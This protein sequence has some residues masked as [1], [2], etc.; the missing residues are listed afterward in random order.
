MEEPLDEWND[1]L[2]EHALK[3]GDDLGFTKYFWKECDQRPADLA[4]FQ[5]F[6][7]S[8]QKAYEG[9]SSE[10]I[11]EHTGV[12]T[13]TV[14]SWILL[15]KMPKLAHYLK[16]YLLL[17]EPGGGLVWLSVDIGTHGIPM[18]S[19]LRVPLEVDS[20]NEVWKVISQPESVDLSQSEMN[21][22]YH[23]GFLLGMIV[24][25]T[26]KSK[27]AIG[28]RHL[29]LT[30]SQKYETNLKL[31]E[32]TSSCA[33]SLGL[34]MH[35]IKDIPQP[36]WKPHGFFA[37]VSQASPL[38]DWIYNVGLGLRD[39]QVTTY[40]S[41]KAEWVFNSPRE[42]RVGLVQGLAESDGS[43]NVASQSVEFWIGPNW[44]WMIRLLATF[45]LRAF[46]SRQAVALSKSQAIKSFEVPIFSNQIRTMRFQ[47]HE[48]LATTHRLSR[49]D[50]LS[51][52]LRTEIMNLA[53]QGLSASKIVEDIAKR[54]GVL[55]S[56][57]AAQRWANKV[58]DSNIV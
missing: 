8:L 35:R 34:R 29:A 39:D 47:R 9:E 50:R 21:R 28:H 26:A 48:L 36:R 52:T 3:Y 5:R 37:W 56:F 11:A 24:G 18:G 33:R 6:T 12:P 30:L 7:L 46:R 45:G 10:A 19:F 25:D 53:L 41:I 2:V 42:F 15:D 20:W 40:D 1:K 22:E 16:R 51:E 43:P 31:G 23:F 49:T 44:D 17:G 58:M 57:E 14:D 13:P 32:F 55:I 4:Q 54:R 38:I 27:P